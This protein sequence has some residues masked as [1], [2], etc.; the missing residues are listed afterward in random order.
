MKYFFVLIFLFSNAWAEVSKDEVDS[1]IDQMVKSNAIS[2]QEAQKARI[3]L[4]NLSPEQWS[5]L[6]VEAKAFAGRSPASLPAASQKIDLDNAQL[7]Q[8]EE[9]IKKFVPQN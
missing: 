7:K 3:R 2:A 1:M 6:N 4:K 9:D 5:E 8:I